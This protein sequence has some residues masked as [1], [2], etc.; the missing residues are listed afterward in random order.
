MRTFIMG[1]HGFGLISSPAVVRA[2]D[3]SGFRAIVDLGGATG[4][5]TIAACEL[6]PRMRGIVLDLDRVIP[7]ARE[8]TARS[9]AAG[10]IECVAGDF[11]TGE[12]P[13]G[14]LFAMGRILHDWSRPKID[15]LLRRIFDRLPEGGGLLLAERL[16]AEDRSGPLGAAMQ[17][18]NMLICTEGKEHTKTEYTELLLAAGFREV[19]TAETGLALDAILALK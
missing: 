17:S 1:M 6:Y 8:I 3:L 4:H 19:R 2:F 10:R 14:D 13:E 7:V 9:A 16:L 12:L 11:F 15:L 5:L 18:I